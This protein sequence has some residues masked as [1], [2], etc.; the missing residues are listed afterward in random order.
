M[1]KKIKLQKRH[2]NILYLK[3]SKR[4]LTKQKTLNKIRATKL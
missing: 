2:S 4:N 3:K 1:E